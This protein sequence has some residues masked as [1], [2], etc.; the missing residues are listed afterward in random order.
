[1]KDEPFCEA[2]FQDLLRW[3]DTQN[4]IFYSND[5]VYPI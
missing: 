3:M 2:E 4:Y 1:M 5:M